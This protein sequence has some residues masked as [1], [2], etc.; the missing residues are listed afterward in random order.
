MDSDDS[1]RIKKIK[2]NDVIRFNQFSNL[3]SAT[4]RTTASNL[5]TYP[6]QKIECFEDLAWNERK[7]P[8]QYAK[9]KKMKEKKC[10]IVYQES[11]VSPIVKTSDFIESLNVIINDHKIEQESESEKNEVIEYSVEYFGSKRLINGI[12]AF[13]T[14][15]AGYESEANTNETIFNLSN[16]LELLKIRENIAMSKNM[17]LVNKYCDPLTIVETALY[18]KLRHMIKPSHIVAYVRDKKMCVVAFHNTP[19]LA[20]LPLDLVLRDYRKLLKVFI[21]YLRC[22]D[23]RGSPQPRKN[24]VTPSC[25]SEEKGS[26]S[27]V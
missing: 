20:N 13:E 1:P 5:P 15:W 23:S 25:M 2:R 16:S 19:D 10:E 21:K 22:M 11:F 26:N 17:D 14:K 8:L 6:P 7:Y 18:S 27:S 12:V 3:S 9:V 24:R 4:V